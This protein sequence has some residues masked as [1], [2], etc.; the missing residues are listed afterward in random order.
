MKVH[1]IRAADFSAHTY[2]AVLQ[3]VTS[4]PGPVNYVPSETEVQ[5]NQAIEQ[6]ISNRES[7]ETG[8]QPP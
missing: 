6:E 4:F 3:I 5:I 2:Q 1:L 7:F 8:K